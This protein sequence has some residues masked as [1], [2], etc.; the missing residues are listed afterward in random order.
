MK[1]V[2]L[3]IVYRGLP[4]LKALNKDSIQRILINYFKPNPISN[5]E[6]EKGHCDSNP[7]FQFTSTGLQKPEQIQPQGST[8]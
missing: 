2:S 7:C 3:L 5:G 6:K 8:L 4:C 1:C